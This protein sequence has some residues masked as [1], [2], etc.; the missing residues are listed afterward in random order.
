[1]SVRQVDKYTGSFCGFCQIITLLMALPMLFLSMKTSIFVPGRYEYSIQR[2]IFGVESDLPNHSYCDIFGVIVSGF[3][4]TTIETRWFQVDSYTGHKV[5]FYYSCVI[6]Y[7][8]ISSQIHLSS[9]MLK[10]IVWRLFVSEKLSQ[11]N[12]LGKT[13]LSAFARVN[14]LTGCFHTHQYHTM[15][16]IFP[17][18]MYIDT[19]FS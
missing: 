15:N 17:A 3:Y 12:L 4:S 13:H 10:Y 2:D 6:V 8:A 11:N 16:S 18:R 19:F 5:V 9:I 7:F 14:Q 1:M